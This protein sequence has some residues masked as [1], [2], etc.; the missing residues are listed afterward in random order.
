MKNIKSVL[1]KILKK[2]R[3]SKMLRNAVEEILKALNNKDYNTAYQLSACKSYIT[4]HINNDIDKY[5]F[6]EDRD[7]NNKAIGDSVY[8]LLDSIHSEIALKLNK[9]PS[10]I[11]VISQ[12]G[13]QMMVHESSHPVIA[14]MVYEKKMVEEELRKIYEKKMI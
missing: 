1:N 8:R 5:A 14:R 6:R 13:I 2:A 11:T 10:G 4:G 7:F 9:I 3:I 12:E